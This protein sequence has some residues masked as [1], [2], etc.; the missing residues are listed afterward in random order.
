M[1][2][3]DEKTK[4]EDRKYE[5]VKN[6]D[7][8]LNDLNTDIPKL[9]N[10]LWEKPKIVCSIIQNSKKNFVKK[11]LSSLFADNFYENILSSNSMED[12]LMYLLTLLLEGEINKLNDINESEEFLDN[13]N[14]GFIL[15]KLRFKKDIQSY[16]KSIISNSIE[17]LEKNHSSLNINFNLS[18]I[19]EQIDKTKE[20][21]KKHSENKSDYKKDKEEKEEK[22]IFTKKYLPDL[23]KESLEQLLN[24]NKD[25]KKLYDFLNKK[26]NDCSCI[27][28]EFIYAN[29]AL[30]NINLLSKIFHGNNKIY[31]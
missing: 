10:D 12:R 21:D 29:K 2:L 20:I 26:I 16:F 19:S 14:C 1:N 5:L 7:E 22:I 27:S 13:S 30:R 9:M 15:E 25:N 18:K 4:T 8:Y 11:H 3:I 24:E 6:P 28:D 31:Q 17:N 23:D